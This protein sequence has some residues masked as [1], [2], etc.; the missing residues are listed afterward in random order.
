MA[1]KK[2]EIPQALAFHR[3]Y[4]E[5]MTQPPYS[6]ATSPFLLHKCCINA[7]PKID[8]TAA[9]IKQWWGKYREVLLSTYGS[10]D[11]TSIYDIPYTLG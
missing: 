11:S 3:E 10:L 7:S 2:G 1:P 4:A 9:T 6:E 5:R 8:V